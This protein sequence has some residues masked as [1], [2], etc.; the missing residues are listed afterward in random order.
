MEP[1]HLYFLQ[2][3]CM[4]LRQVAQI[5]LG[6]QDI[7]DSGKIVILPK[8]KQ[9]NLEKRGIY[10]YGVLS[11]SAYENCVLIKESTAL[12]KS[13]SS[14]A[15]PFWIPWA[16]KGG[17]LRKCTLHVIRAHPLGSLRAAQLLLQNQA[18][19]CVQQPCWSSGT[20]FLFPERFTLGLSYQSSLKLAAP[21]SCHIK[22][23]TEVSDLRHVSH[24]RVRLHK[25]E[26]WPLLLSF[27][28][29]FMVYYGIGH[30]MLLNC[31]GFG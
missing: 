23:W 7:F 14:P 6:V 17:A 9:E 20:C 24:S 4:I 16:G 30:P 3:P 31:I 25:C 28:M 21:V 1:R 5:L 18:K 26:F 22:L 29:Q 19:S 10:I 13:H 27:Q 2:A 11:F 8:R 15:A 12:M